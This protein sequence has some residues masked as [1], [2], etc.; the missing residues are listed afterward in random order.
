MVKLRSN[1]KRLLLLISISLIIIGLIPHLILTIISNSYYSY[2]IEPLSLE[3]EDGT[4]I[5]AFKYTPKG[6]KN[7]G[8]IVVGHYF[9]GNKYHMHPLS[10]ELVKRGF[11]VINIDFRGHGTSGGTIL[12]SEFINDMNAAVDYLEYNLPYI[13]EIGLVGHSLGARIALALA[14]AYPNRINATVAIG[15]L[16]SNVAGISNLLM[17]IGK[18]EHFV[19]EEDLLEALRMYTGQE[20]VKIGEIYYGD[21][22]GGNNTKGFI[23]SFSEH[24]FEVMDPSIVYQTVQWFEQ[25]FNGGVAS[26]IFITVPFFQIFSYISLFGIIL[27]SFT[28]IVYLSNFLFKYKI[29]YPEKELYYKAREISIYNLISYYAIYV[30]LIG[31][32][33]FLVLSNILKGVIFLT[34]T[35]LILTLTIGTAIGTL[36]IFNFLIL[37]KQEK[38]SIISFPLKIREMCLTNSRRSMIYGV[39]AGLLIIF[40]FA[41]TWH[42]IPQNILPNLSEILTMI[43]IILISFP[44]FLIKEFYFRNVQGGLKTSNRSVEYFTMVCIGIFMDNFLIAMIKLF[45]WI[46]LVYMPKNALYLSVWVVFS[47]L[48]QFT[49][50]WVYM[51]SGRNILGSTIFLS[52]FYA[53]MSIIYLPSFGFL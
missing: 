8:G 20:N 41:I 51:W 47:I 14:R 32:L 28:L 38:L 15:R 40:S 29:S 34:T 11:T 4:Y 53:W 31:F 33:I 37:H 6:E 5:S 21:F 19:T 46:N 35:S 25:A 43:G 22:N 42:W 1:K 49:T 17:A 52:V 16:P 39:L 12:D 18:F 26:D 3:S 30:I 36:I 13:T 45:G 50:T 2:T 7:H 10:I 9:T 24:L 27:L 48:Q 44:F 23:G